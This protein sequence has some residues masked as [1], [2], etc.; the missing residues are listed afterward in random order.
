MR[1]TE[2]FKRHLRSVFWVDD[3]KVDD[4]PIED[5]F[6]SVRAGVEIQFSLWDRIKLLW[7]GR[8]VVHIRYHIESDPV[9][10]RRWFN[11]TDVC[12]WCYTKIGDS[13]TQGDPGYHHGDERICEAC[14]YKH[15]IPVSNPQGMMSSAPTN[16]KPQK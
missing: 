5:P 12:E 3:E 2:H 10:Q 15:P 1:G 4:L 9:A 8:H 16:V 13:Y 14:Y 7:T 6:V 11:G